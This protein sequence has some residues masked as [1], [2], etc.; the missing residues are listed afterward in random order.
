[1]HLQVKHKIHWV[2]YKDT[3]SFSCQVQYIYMEMLSVFKVINYQL[4]SIIKHS[5]TTNLFQVNDNL[6]WL[7]WTKELQEYGYKKRLT[8]NKAGSQVSPL[9]Q[10]YKYL[11]VVPPV[12]NSATCSR[13]VMIKWGHE[14]RGGEW[15]CV[16]G[17]GR[18]G[19]DGGEG[20][21]CFVSPTQKEDSCFRMKVDPPKRAS[22][23]KVH[24]SEY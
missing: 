7:C 11:C 15:M 13:V 17:S 9:V 8:T 1:M 22:F 23:G 18:Q 4:C 6:S 21:R 19:G 5:P 3:F 20:E 2:P 14:R 24:F 10:F 16:V 12:R